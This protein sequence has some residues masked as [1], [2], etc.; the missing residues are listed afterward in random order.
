M[1]EGSKKMIPKKQFKEKELNCKRLRVLLNRISDDIFRKCL[2]DSIDLNHATAQFS[3]APSVQEKSAD[4]S[5]HELFIDENLNR[6]PTTD[7]NVISRS[8]GIYCDKSSKEQVNFLVDLEVTLLSK[9]THIEADT[10]CYVSEDENNEVHQMNVKRSTFWDQAITEKDIHTSKVQSNSLKT[11]S[12]K[13]KSR[14]ISKTKKIRPNQASRVPALKDFKIVCERLPHDLYQIYSKQLCVQKV[15]ESKDI[16]CKSQ[17]VQH[18]VTS[19]NCDKK[20]QSDKPAKS[21]PEANLIKNIDY[22]KNLKSNIKV[23]SKPCSHVSKALTDMKTHLKVCSKKT[24]RKESNNMCEVAIPPGKK[25]KLSKSTDLKNMEVKP[26]LKRQSCDERSAQKIEKVSDKL[27]PSVKTSEVQFKKLK[28]EL[29]SNNVAFGNLQNGSK[30]SSKKNVKSDSLRKKCKYC[31]KREKYKF[32]NEMNFEEGMKDATKE[33]SIHETVSDIQNMVAKDSHPSSEN[34]SYSQNVAF[35]ELEKSD[36]FSIDKSNNP[37]DVMINCRELKQKCKCHHLSKSKLKVKRKEKVSLKKQVGALKAN[38]CTTDTSSILPL[39]NSISLEN[40]PSKT[41][42]S[43]AKALP[44]T[45]K[46]KICKMKT[47]SKNCIKKSEGNMIK[48]KKKGDV[49]KSYKG[50]KLIEKF[51]KLNR[52]EKKKQQCSKKASHKNVSQSDDATTNGNSCLPLVSQNLNFETSNKVPFISNISLENMFS[53]TVISSVKAL[54]GTRNLKTDKMKNVSKN[55]VQKRGGNI[56]RKK[57]EIIN[58][59]YHCVNHFEKFSQLNCIKNK[60]SRCSKKTCDENVLE[61]G[62]AI[63]SRTNCLPLVSQN[64]KFGKT[65]SFNKIAGKNK[66]SFNCVYSPKESKTAM[67]L[68]R[69]LENRMNKLAKTGASS[70]SFQRFENMTAIQ[71]ISFLS[72]HKKLALYFSKILNKSF[73]MRNP[74]NSGAKVVLHGSN[75]EKQNSSAN[76][77]IKDVSDCQNSPSS[78]KTLRV[79]L[80]RLSD[81]HFNF[82]NNAKFANTTSCKETESLKNEDKIL[83]TPTKSLLKKDN[84][85]KSPVS[86]KVTFNLDI[87]DNE[88]SFYLSSSTNDIR[89]D[90][91]CAQIDSSVLKIDGFGI[92][93]VQVVLKPINIDTNLYTVKKRNLASLEQPGDGTVSCL[94]QVNSPVTAMFSKPN[95]SNI[96]KIPF[97]RERERNLN[98]VHEWEKQISPVSSK[99]L[100]QS[101]NESDLPSGIILPNSSSDENVIV[102]SNSLCN[103]LVELDAVGAC[104][105]EVLDAISISQK[106]NVENNKEKKRKT[107]SKRFLKKYT[108]LK[109]QLGFLQLVKKNRIQHALRLRQRGVGLKKKPKKCDKDSVDCSMNKIA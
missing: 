80:S 92:K 34:A 6:G 33:L 85:C 84:N 71:F 7:S 56:K 57:R 79:V 96:E 1:L 37:S 9:D 48:G 65:N 108:S 68:K 72:Q 12:P 31:R 49:K 87:K 89:T 83:L 82:Y 26:V 74:L 62:D 47:V 41:H 40:V 2:T 18:Q 55:C 10:N 43:S 97:S 39:N 59:G 60:K 15:L 36:M 51:S 86:K 16:A 58:K 64:L 24:E 102:D 105:N 75:V 52:I 5:Q 104:V 69:K 11:R 76:K 66:K 4:C 25:T 106:E 107:E 88:D 20:N 42:I 90:D 53:E 93:P 21:I 98:S 109:Y 94:E 35:E 29:S 95:I 19:A 28:K 32:I 99:E 70:K 73:V 101:L 50:A 45:E 81:S 8:T 14:T 17:N 77:L 13:I 3:V 38:K 54:P 27:H 100:L 67:L 30:I 91:V 103:Q 78:S 22:K 46:L 44:S 23:Q 63:N 61:S